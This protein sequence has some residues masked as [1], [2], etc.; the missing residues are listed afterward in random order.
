[1][2][3]NGKTGFAEYIFSTWKPGILVLFWVTD[4]LIFLLALYSVGL[5][6][7]V[8]VLFGAAVP[9]IIVTWAWLS[10][11]TKYRGQH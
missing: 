1:M 2:S 5:R 8:L 10:G 11:R 3:Q 9:T 4:V 6:F 7:A